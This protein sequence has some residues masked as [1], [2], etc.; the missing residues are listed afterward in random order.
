MGRAS[1]GDNRAAA[2][3]GVD[4][5][6]TAAKRAAPNPSLLDAY[7]SGHLDDLFPLR[8]DDLEGALALPRAVDRPTLVAALR[9]SFARW[10][11]SAAQRAALERL[12]HPEARVVVTGQQIGW[13]LGPTYTLSKAA[14]AVALARALDRPERP[15]VPVFWMATQDH[16]VAEIDHAWI[17]GRD[18]QLHRLQLPL[19][20]GPAV[21]RAALDPA[22]VK[23]AIDHLRAIDRAD[24]RGGPHIEVVAQLLHDACDG[25]ARWSDAFARLLGALFGDAGLL[26]LDPL[27][28]AVARL[29]QPQLRRELADPQASAEQVRVGAARLE[30]R[31][32]AAQLGRAEGASNLF[33]ERGRGHPR[34]LLRRDGDSWRVG[35]E[36]VHL[37]E[38]KVLLDH[39]PTAITPAAGLRPTLQD[40]L[41]PTAAFV[42][43]PGELRYLAQLRGVYE[44]HGVAMPLIWPRA[45]ATLLQPPVRR[46]LERYEVDWRALQADP[47]RLRG[48][49]ALRLHQHAEAFTAAAVR[50]EA[51][52]AV[53]LE[54]VSHIDP[55]LER[56]V[57]LGERQFHRTLL[58]LRE[59]TAL[60][61]GRRDETLRAQFQRLEQHLRPNGGLQERVLSPFT[62]FLT[63][64]PQA[65]RDAFLALP[66]EGDHAI[67]F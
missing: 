55:T 3:G 32:Y 23:G 51:E 43:G 16:D 56:S 5:R 27:E 1:A 4:W 11:T 34:E 54:R 53:L 18:E 42:V 29:W 67:R 35:S 6:V 13:L 21:G 58:R 64:G 9:E 30:V 37:E 52:A 41:L 61:L 22:S 31:G 48:E 44:H 45:T 8:A 60:A 19:R 59:K 26:P 33:V 47:Q 7:R 28:P 10:G 24:G 2:V 46:I 36:R 38:L 15:V 49:V 57:Q 12:S 65:V 14:T 50:I 39:D 66:T 62:F 17:L 63:L 25:A 40:A 20:S